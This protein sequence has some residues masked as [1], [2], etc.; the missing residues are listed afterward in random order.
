MTQTYWKQICLRT[1]IVLLIGTG[2][3]FTFYFILPLIYPFIIAW[4][5]AML[6]DP[7]VKFLENKVHI[8]RWLAVTIALFVLLVVISIFFIFL[9]GE[10]VIVLASLSEKLPLFFKQITQ[11]FMD[12]FQKN[13]NINKIIETVQNYL[14]HNP[15]HQQNISNSIS[16][17]IDLIAKKASELITDLLAGIGS[18]IG[19]LPYFF[20]VLAV[21]ILATFF[22]SLDW[23]NIKQKLYRLTPKSLQRTGGLVFHGLR[24]ALF[25]FIRAQLTLISI[26][27][28]IVLISLFILKV[29]YAISIAFLIAIVDL[30]PYLGV[31][32]V[33][34][35][36]IVYLF[37][38]GQLKL[39][40]GLLIV[41]AITIIVRQFLEPKLVAHNVGLDPLI[42]LISLFVG[43]NLF[44]VLGL[45]LG[46]VIMVTILTLAQAHVFKDIWN[47]I[48][49]LPTQNEKNV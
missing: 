1:L 45:I 40:L 17:N 21:V 47:Y 18:F 6:L 38:S 29:E 37:L 10:L 11:L 5:I 43:L 23:P 42:A 49:G 22:I 36:W 26:T 24:T 7:F 28:L 39:A 32:A 33:L 19:N 35:P 16:T 12:T 20:T 15:Q 41:Y 8:P 30:L 31:G 46:P 27:G 3:F 13:Q 34:V 9:I 44:G 48:I 14:T 4:A 2:V 25:G